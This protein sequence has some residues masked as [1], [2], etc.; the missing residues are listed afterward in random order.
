M[1]GSRLQICNMALGHLRQ[2]E[3]RDYDERSEG[4]RNCRLYYNDAVRATLRAFDWP[5]A[6]GWVTPPVST[7]PP[8]PGWR[9]S[10]VLPADCLRVREIWRRNRNDPQIKYE[11]TAN[12]QRPGEGV[13]L[14]CNMS[15][16]TVIYTVELLDA[17]AFDASFVQALSYQLALQLAMPLTGKAAL[18]EVQR[19][20]FAQ[21]LS[22][23]QTEAANEEPNDIG[24]DRTP[25]WIRARNGDCRPYPLLRNWGDY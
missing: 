14:H 22:V 9:Y 5:F 24:E 23:A 19:K 8:K 3:L 6:R 15:A 13:V 18:A 17:Q 12:M 21:T 7:M 4:A 20:M 10:F 25:D 1:A 2:Q 11:V 16:P